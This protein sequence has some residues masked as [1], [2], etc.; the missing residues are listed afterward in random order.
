MF[1]SCAH[2]SVPP[3]IRGN[4]QHCGVLPGCGPPVSHQTRLCSVSAPDQ[5]DNPS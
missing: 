5:A 2:P 1:C 4:S 3:Q